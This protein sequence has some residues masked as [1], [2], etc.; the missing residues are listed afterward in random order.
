M[1]QKIISLPDIGTVTLQKRKG[2]R[3]IRL[4]V[5]HDGSLKVSMPTW[6]PYHVAEAFV[7]SKSAWIRTQQAG[8]GHKLL[9]DGHRMGK[10]HR[11][12][13]E[14]VDS[15]R[16]TSRVTKTEIIVR[17][18]I[19][20]DPLETTAQKQARSATLR[21]LKQEAAHLLPQRIETLAALHAFTYRT[22]AIK[23]LKARWGS[24]NSQK[25]I[26]LSCYLM[27][28]PWELIDY[29]LLHELVHTRVMA[30]GKPFW[31]ELGKYVTNLSDKRKAI[32][33]HRPTLL[34]QP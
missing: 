34:P 21:A 8:K 32:R 6:S 29:V 33:S 14:Y 5:G 27:Q 31:D 7:L 22:V 1:A 9:H 12:R 23:Q 26:T 25:D 16:M 19:G 3:S 10:A 4:T 17:L 28:L 11:I 2:T 20:H 13:Y 24:C 30:H 18:P 15:L